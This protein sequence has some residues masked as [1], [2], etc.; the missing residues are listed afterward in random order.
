MKKCPI[1]RFN[2]FQIGTWDFGPWTIVKNGA[3]PPSNHMCAIGVFGILQSNSV[4]R[5]QF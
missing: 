1:Q 2:L 5:G 3:K 4:S